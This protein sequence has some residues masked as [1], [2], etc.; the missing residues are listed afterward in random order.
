[1]NPNIAALL[2]RIRSLQ[3]ELENEWIKRNAEFN[4]SL[5]EKK[6][7]FDEFIRRQ[8]RE[9]RRGLLGYLLS[10]RLLIL[11]IAPVI[12]LMI[13]PIIFLDFFFSMYQMMCFPVYG[14]S[15][16]R[17]SDYLIFD[18]NQLGYLNVIEKINCAYCS[19]GNGVLAYAREIAARTEQY[20]CPI[21]HARRAPDF[22]GLYPGFVDYGDAKA[23][24]DEL[25]NLRK[26]L[27][28]R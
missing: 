27:R 1:M 18:R 15:L 14:I 9:Y 3:E 16:V 22:H 17:R 28:K 26:Q 21:K 19:Y 20:W 12:Y 24:H 2:M 6:V 25:E 11:M 23:Y 8:H 5:H 10:A 7:I 13:V 4:Y